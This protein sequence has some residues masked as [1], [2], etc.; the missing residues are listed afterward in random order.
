VQDLVGYGDQW[1]GELIR[2]M[3]GRCVQWQ[4]AVTRRQGV[5]ERSALALRHA[6]RSAKE[7]PFVFASKALAVQKV[8]CPVTIR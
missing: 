7:I 1:L 8:L 5:L 4:S 2:E 3:L 6:P